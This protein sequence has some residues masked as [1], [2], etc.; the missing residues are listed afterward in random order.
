M[1]EAARRSKEERIIVFNDIVTLATSG[2]Q[3]WYIGKN[4][5]EQCGAGTGTPYDEY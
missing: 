3:R 5:V 1:P 2:P 4:I